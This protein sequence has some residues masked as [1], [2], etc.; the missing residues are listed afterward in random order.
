MKKTPAFTLIELLIVV[1]IIA[2]L[3]AIA[4]PSLLEAQVRA[5]VARV[6]AD[7]RSM[8]TAIETYFVDYNI[9]PPWAFRSGFGQWTYNYAVVVQAG[10]TGGVGGLPCFLMNNM[11]NSGACFFTLTTPV[12]YITSYPPD[13]FAT[14]RGATF[15]Y[16]SIFP[17]DPNLAL[18]RRNTV[19]HS[20]SFGEE[21]PFAFSDVDDIIGNIQSSG[22]YTHEIGTN[23]D[24]PYGPPPPEPPLGGTGWIIWS[25]GPDTDEYKGPVPSDSVYTAYNPAV[26]QPSPRLLGLTY[27]PTNGTLSNGDVWR[28]KQ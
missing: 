4:I 19:M 17:G 22:L 11:R 9:F 20:L 13:P 24:T 15:G 16:V 23:L 26:T 12:A 21:S 5:K 28:V 18:I 6:R 3:A 27:D 7:Q 10:H 25:L 2:I 1:A 8:A 14:N